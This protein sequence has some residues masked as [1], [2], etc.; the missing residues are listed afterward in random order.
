[1]QKKYLWLNSLRTKLFS[2]LLFTIVPLIIVLLVINHYSAQVVRNQVAQS[3]KNL[4]SLYMGQI[5][6]SLQEVDNYLINLSQTNLDLLDFDTDKLANENNYTKAKL[7]LFQLIKD[8]VSYYKGIDSFFIYSGR[9]KELLMTQ[10]FGNGFGEREQVA[11]EIN[12]M[13]QDRSVTPNVYRWYTWQ[14]EGNHYLYHVIKSGNVYVGAWVDAKK[15]MIPLQLINLGSNGAALLTSDQLAPM[16]HEDLITQK[17]IRL[18]LTPKTYTISGT[19]EDYL[20]MGEPSQKGN[21][22]LFTLIPEVVA[23]ENLPYLQRISSIVSI[24]AI[25]FLLLFV[26]YM[27]KVFLL[28]INRIILAMR[29][30]GEGRWNSQIEHYP[31][32]TEFGIMNET[33]NRMI[34]EIQYLKINVYEEKLMHQ[35]AELKQLQLQIN[36]HF[37]LNSLNIIYNLATVKDFKLIHEMTKCL[38]TYFRF[39][40]RS[41]SYVVTLK[42]ELLHTQNYLRIQELRFPGVLTYQIE[43]P[44]A[45]LS[46]QIPPLVIQTMVENTIKHAVNLDERIQIDIRVHTDEDEQQEWV[47]IH[48]EDTGPGFPEPILELLKGN[49]DLA[50]EEGEHIGIWNV[51]RRLH[52]LYANKATIDFYN[53]TDKGACVRIRIPADTPLTG[54]V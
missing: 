51:K 9:N 24:G 5:D 18:A 46:L 11:N 7:R 54:G 32:S 17:G 27:R 45:V 14:S 48:I 12:R 34:T 40:F 20:V 37:F 43:A 39:M 10:G 15:L 33:Y 28:P 22:Y 25:V 21:F 36:P 42:E 41:N 1:M 31:T 52:L 44:D 23:L 35:H 26:I 13:L 2:G 30:L 6:R 4:M 50:S 53:E 8:D 19:K 29:K 49:M 3:N 38:V 47:V 16:S